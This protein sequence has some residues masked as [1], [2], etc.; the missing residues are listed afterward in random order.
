[1]GAGGWTVTGLLAAAL[2]A[3]VGLLGSHVADLGWRM[4]HLGSELRGEMA[5]QGSELGGRMTHLESELRAGSHQLGQRIDHLSDRIDNLSG[6]V[7][8]VATD[9]AAHMADRTRH[10]A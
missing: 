2:F 7:D 1:M 9:L 4:T 8:D 5:R 6:R 10:T 3:V